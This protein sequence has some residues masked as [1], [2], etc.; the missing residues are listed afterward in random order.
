MHTHTE[1]RNL[2]I[3]LNIFRKK[4]K[5]KYE[6]MTPMKTSLIL[7][8]KLMT[9]NGLSLNNTKICIIIIFNNETSA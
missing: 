7:S 8:S 4:L 2:D 1:P 5:F 6:K 9:E 3:T